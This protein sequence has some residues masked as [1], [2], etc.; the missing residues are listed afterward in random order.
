LFSF[1]GF[2]KQWRGFKLATQ[3]C[4]LSEWQDHRAL[5]T[6]ALAYGE[7]GDFASAVEYERKAIKLASALFKMLY[8][9]RLDHFLAGKSYSEVSH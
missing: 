4:E 1:S 6:L 3:A 2:L 9:E 5:D 8:R 7:M